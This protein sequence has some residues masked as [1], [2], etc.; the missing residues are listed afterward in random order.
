LEPVCIVGGAHFNGPVF[1]GGGDSLSK[2]GIER[3][4][5][6]LGVLQTLKNGGR[7]TLFHR[8]FVKDLT[9]EID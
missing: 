6:L 5:K 2:I 4:A 7:E 1:H 9:G 3:V 8:G